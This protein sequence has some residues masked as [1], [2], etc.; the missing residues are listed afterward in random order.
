VK[1][2]PGKSNRVIVPSSLFVTAKTTA[3][4]WKAMPT[5]LAVVEKIGT[6]LTATPDRFKIVTLGGETVVTNR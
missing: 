4:V 5:G 2:L 3:P 6:A 1:S